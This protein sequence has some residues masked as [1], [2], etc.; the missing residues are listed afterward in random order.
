MKSINARALSSNLRKHLRA[1]GYFQKDLA[2]EL[3]LHPKVLSRKISGNGNAHL[4]EEEARRIIITLAQWQAITTQN[5][6][7]QLLELAQKKQ[8]SFSAQEWQTHPLNLLTSRNTMHHTHTDYA[9]RRSIRHNLP[10]QLTRLV[11][12]EEEV[13]QLRQ[14]LR[15]EE[16][17]LVTLVGPGGSGKTRLALHVAKELV[18]TFAQGVWLVS[19]AAVRDS[20][21][22]LLSIMQVLN[23][24]P[25]PA[26]SAIQSLTSHLQDKQLLLLLDNFEQVRDAAPAIGELLAAAP[27]LKVLVTSRTVLHLY[28]ENEFKVPPLGVPDTSDVL[29]VT[30]LAQYGAVQLF[31]GRARAVEPSFALATENAASIAQICARVDG[32]PLALELA[33]ARVKILPPAVL[34]A[35]LSEARLSVLTRGAKNLP[36]RQ[37]TMR[38]TIRWSYDLLTPNDKA[39][40]ARLGV[41]SGGWS[42]EAAEAMVQAIATDLDHE[43]ATVSGFTLDLLERLV[44]N[45]LLVRLPMTAGHVRFTLLET[46]HAYAMERLNAHGELE[47]LRDWHTC[48]Y[49]SVAE[50]AEIGLRGPQQL[51]WQTRLVT[52]Q[53]NFRAALKWSLQ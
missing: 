11:G 47:R 6:A 38:N 24:K 12:R 50:T 51:T 2:D 28:G 30:K 37:H 22:L 18:D 15:Q 33:A 23:I 43:D 46:L 53:D 1:A 42:L 3:G 14:M 7:L 40:F 17:R 10:A 45:C 32:L 8:S 26:L 4:T 41:F 39:W 20:A 13:E 35:R 31:V 27:G 44:D 25:A 19:L 49:L 21:L 36:D 48:F 16:V 29:D 52:E 5:E 34:L 9:S